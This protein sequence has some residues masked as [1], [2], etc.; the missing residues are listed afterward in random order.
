MESAVNLFRRDRRSIGVGHRKRQSIGIVGQVALSL[1]PPLLLLGIHLHP[2]TA[3]TAS[4]NAVQ[5]A[6]PFRVGTNPD[7]S[8]ADD[9]G[10]GSGCCGGILEPARECEAPGDVAGGGEA[11][12]GRSPEQP[13]G[14]EL[15]GFAGEDKRA[16]VGSEHSAKWG[17]VVLGPKC[18]FVAEW[19]E[20]VE[21][22]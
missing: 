22:G 16:R 15:A 17:V 21:E 12:E 3:A 18:I 20:M 9:I 13:S 10:G 7:A 11:A 6:T 19:S 5:H 2:T 8:S 14:R 4:C 1:A